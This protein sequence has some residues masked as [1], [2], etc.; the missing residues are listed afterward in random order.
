MILIRSKFLV[1]FLTFR[2]ANAIALFPFVIIKKYDKD[3][4]ET[5]LNH[6]RIHLRQQLELLLIGFYIMYVVEF[7]LHYFR[8]KSRQRAYSS[9]SFEREAYENEDNPDYLK[10]RGKWAFLKYLDF[11]KQ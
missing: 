8:L 6:E 9:I 5:M 10:M 7:I 3:V 1:N 2:F 4:I 11:N